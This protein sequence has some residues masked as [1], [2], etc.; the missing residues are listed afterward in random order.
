MSKK[1]GIDIEVASTVEE[2][3]RGSDIIVTCTSST[4]PFI[5]G[6][7]IEEGIHIS[8][9]GADTRAKRELEGDFAVPLQEGVIRKEDIYMLN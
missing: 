2:A 6:D 7:M 3:V 1:V 5:K 8:A 4:K 9:I